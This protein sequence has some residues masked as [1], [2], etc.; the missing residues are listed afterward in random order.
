[1][2]KILTSAV[3]AATLVT[4]ASAE[5]LTFEFDAMPYMAGSKTTTTGQSFTLG[6]KVNDKLRAGIFQENGAIT[7]SD[8]GASKTGSYTATALNLEYS[9]YAKEVDAI[10][11]MNIGSL[12]NQAIALPAGSASI[13]A[14]SNL[15]TDLYAKVS[16]NASEHAFLN[17]KLGYRMVAITDATVATT[18]FDNQ[19]A[20]FIKV[21]VGVKF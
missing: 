12:N 14:G 10:I 15:L 3:L 21:G 16:Y 13:A 18:A 11:G 8:K 6:F 2:K 7:L 19:N 17:L 1:M 9:A 5:F 20:P 4:S